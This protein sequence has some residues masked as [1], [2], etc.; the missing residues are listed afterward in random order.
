MGRPLATLGDLDDPPWGPARLGAT[1]AATR[2]DFYVFAENGQ[3]RL[4]CSRHVAVLT[5]QDARALAEALR[6]QAD[7]QD[8]RRTRR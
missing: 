6:V 7:Q 8:A 2:A 1:E 4:E 3:V 5:P